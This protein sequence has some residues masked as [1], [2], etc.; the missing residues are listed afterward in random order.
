MSLDNAWLAQNMAHMML[1]NMRMNVQTCP[2]N[3]YQV[4]LAK[5]NDK[6]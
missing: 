5:E 2:N 1:Q 3:D 4:P 6:K